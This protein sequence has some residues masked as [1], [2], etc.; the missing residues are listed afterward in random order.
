[1]E[2]LVAAVPLQLVTRGTAS[3]GQ[4]LV[5]LLHDLAGDLR[6]HCARQHPLAR[7]VTRPSIV[8]AQPRRELSATRQ[9]INPR[10]SRVAGRARRCGRAT[11]AGRTAAELEA[12]CLRCATATRC[13][14]LMTPF[15]V[16]VP[17]ICCVIVGLAA[18]GA[19]YAQT[20]KID[21]CSNA[22]HGGCKSGCKNASKTLKVAVAVILPRTLPR[23][24]GCVL[25]ETR[26]LRH[27]TGHL[28]ARQR[29]AVAATATVT[30]ATASGHRLQP[31]AFSA[32]QPPLPKPFRSAA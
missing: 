18:G 20:R 15:I 25:D 31:H 28:H 1:M 26:E 19:T 13:T 30:T 2:R 16:S 22:G 6:A 5:E 29:R 17:L 9:P 4:G 8:R 12:S 10:T 32:S 23:S 21:P 3:S 7:C 14:P 24:C 27:T 11:F